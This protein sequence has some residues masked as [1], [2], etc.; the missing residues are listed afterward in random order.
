VLR[1]ERLGF[2]IEQAL[3]YQIQGVVD[4]LGRLVGGHDGQIESLARF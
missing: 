3:V 1:F 2:K 4:Q